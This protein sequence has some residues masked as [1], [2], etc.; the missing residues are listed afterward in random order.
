M[1]ISLPKSDVGVQEPRIQWL[2]PEFDAELSQARADEMRDLSEVAGL[3]L[4]PWQGLAADGA[5]RVRKSGKWSAFQVGV[6]ANRQNGKGSILEARQ[7][8]GLFLWGETLQVHTA[9]EFRTAQKHFNRVLSLIEATPTLDRMVSRVRRADGEEAIETKEGTALQFMARSLKSGRGITGDT[10]Y[11]DEAFA[12]K[13]QMMASLMSTMSA[14]SVHGNPQLWYA[15]SAGMPES[16]VW[17]GVRETAIAGDDPRLAYMEWSAPDDADADDPE[18]WRAANPG[19]GIRIS[20]DFIKSERSALGDEEFKRERLGIWAKLGGESVFAP[21]VWESGANEDAKPDD[22]ALYFAVDVSPSR[23]SASIA[24]VSPLSDGRVHVEVVENRVGTSW[25]GS[26]LRELKDKWS[27]AAMVAI[28][29][30]NAESLLPTWKRDGARVKLIRFADYKG[31]CGVFYD[32]VVQGKLDHRDD[33]TLNAAVDGAKQAWAQDNASWYWSRKKSDT[34]ITP[35]VAVTVA[36]A[37]M[38]RKN[39]APA[40]TNKPRGVI[41]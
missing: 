20:E 8:A 22:R 41:L 36:L 37:G 12:L 10:V 16:E 28:A 18:V 19:F 32:L 4:D 14:R 15:S 38:E 33:E 7:L 25:V 13:G 27:P 5:C 34:D 26:R 17:A 1:G 35:L 24:L 9:H 39:R 23:D 21:G 11:L 40:R 3:L 31:A 30:S 2:P 29:G 6:S